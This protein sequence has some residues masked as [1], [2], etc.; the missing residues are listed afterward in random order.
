MKKYIKQLSF[1]LVLVLV[2][3]GCQSS[4][5]KDNDKIRIGIVQILDHPSLDAARQGFIDELAA[6]GY[7]EGEKIII[8][9][10]NA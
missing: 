7:K 6:N 2:L 1:I 10:Q 9:Y 5:K 3:S 8:D 4:T